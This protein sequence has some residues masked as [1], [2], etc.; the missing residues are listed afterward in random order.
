MINKNNLYQIEYKKRPGKIKKIIFVLLVIFAL[1]TGAVTYLK[2]LGIN[3]VDT[4]G[5]F[6]ESLFSGKIFRGNG[7]AVS[8]RGVE[9]QLEKRSSPQAGIAGNEIYIWDGSIIR[10][11]DFNG[12]EIMSYIQEGTKPRLLVNRD[13][14]VA[15]DIE[16]TK[17]SVFENGK[18]KFNEHVDGTI[19][20]SSL[21]DNNILTVVHK[22]EGYK[23]AISVY[24]MNSE[25]PFLFVRKFAAMHPIWAEVDRNKNYL[26]VNKININETVVKTV[27]EFLDMVTGKPLASVDANEGVFVKNGYFRNGYFFCV[28][29]SN[30]LC[31][32]SNFK[33]KYNESLSQKSLSSAV[34]DACFS[35]SETAICMENGFTCIYNSNGLY[36]S[37][38]TGIYP[39]SFSFF[40]NTLAY[41]TGREIIITDKGGNIRKRI[42]T[43]KEALNILIGDRGKAVLILSDSMIIMKI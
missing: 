37:F 10:C 29:G 12:R 4:I 14:A 27:F 7:E 33:I 1:T 18:L 41:N 17:I 35:G 16:G 40:G 21:S 31:I 5:A 20:N 32:D 22:T 8:A 42:N 13:F 2:I 24:D 28:S 23:G 19:L 9:I 36:R 26:A 3:P 15:F 6:A 25:N 39:V 34:K 38:E 43:D 30:V 11:F